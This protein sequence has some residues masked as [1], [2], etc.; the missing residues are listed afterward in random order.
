[1]MEL[2]GR[3]SYACIVMY[4]YCCQKSM[5]SWLQGYLRKM[6]KC[7]ILI[8]AAMY[9]D[10]LRPVQLLSKSLQ[11]ER[12]NVVHSLQNLL[13]ARKA[14]KASNTMVYSIGGAQENIKDEGPEKGLTRCP[15]NW[16]QRW[17]LW[18]PVQMLW[19]MTFG[20]WWREWKK[21][22]TGVMSVFGVGIPRYTDLGCM[23]FSCN[24]Q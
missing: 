10:L 14:I 4:T 11:D 15:A 9:V 1:M 16:L 18:S 19:V 24:Q 21:G 12:A 5:Q 20:V 8:G 3:C 22:L 17:V 23:P 6:T 13:K 7:R 2:R